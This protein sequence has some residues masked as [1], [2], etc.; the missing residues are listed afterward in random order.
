MCV[1]IYTHIYICIYIER[2]YTTKYQAK[3]LKK[4]IKDLKRQF[5]KDAQRWLTST[6]KYA[7]CCLF[8]REM[9]I[10][11]T[12]DIISYLPE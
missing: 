6:E 8:I 10:K 5:P 1:Y 3:N 4:L 12:G 2:A 11:T 7:Q 9:Q